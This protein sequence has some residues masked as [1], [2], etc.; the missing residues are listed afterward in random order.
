MLNKILN[1]QNMLRVSCKPGNNFK[2]GFGFILILLTILSLMPIKLYSQPLFLG[3]KGG[4]SIPEL[5]G[6]GTP[7][8]EGYSSRLAPNFGAY[9]NYELNSY[10]SFQ[11]EVLFSGQGGVRNGMQPIDNVSN[12]PVPPNTSL[13]ANFDNE[14]ILNYLEIPVLIKYNYSRSTSGIYAYIDAG[15]YLGILLNAKTETSGNSNIYLDPSGSTLLTVNGYPV[16]SQDF[17]AETDNSSK[18][19]KVNVGITGGIGIGMSI[20]HSLL[21]LDLRA[22]YGFIPIQADEENGS[23]HTGALYL[24]I[25]YGFKI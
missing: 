5:Q 21:D 11:A 7:Q 24:T 12:L 23:N 4:L 9:I 22:V 14:T 19:N 20:D 2:I 25:G 6:G 18:I 8:S 17:N 10:I 16:P 15:P 3:V 13:Y 1:L